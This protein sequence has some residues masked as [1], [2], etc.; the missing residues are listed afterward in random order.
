[1][2]NQKYFIIFFLSLIAGQTIGQAYS[3]WENHY[4]KRFY[5]KIQ[6]DSYTLD[7]NGEEI[8][9]IYVPTKVEEGIYEIE[10]H[11][12]S[13]KIYQISGKNIYMLFQFMPFLFSFDK[14]ILK[15][16]GNTGTFYKKP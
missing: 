9:E 5:K 14:G 1:M 8:D 3:Q 4:V 6:L 12:V 2:K 10:V 15:V 16:S 11:K 7:K 13:S